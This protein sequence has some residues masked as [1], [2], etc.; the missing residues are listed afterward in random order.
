MSDSKIDLSNWVPKLLDIVSEFRPGSIPTAEQLNDYLNLL[1]EQGDYNSETIEA[2]LS[3][4]GI[5][6]LANSA[7]AD[8][9]K[10]LQAKVDAG[11]FNGPQGPVGEKGEAGPQGPVGPQGPKGEQG[12][13]GVQGTAGVNGTDGK[14]GKDGNNGVI[15][16]IT[17]NEYGFEI[18]DGHLYIVYTDGTDVPTFEL[19]SDY[20]LIQKYTDDNGEILSI[21]LGNVRGPVGSIGDTDEFLKA[22]WNLVKDN[23]NI[24]LDETEYKRA[25]SDVLADISSDT[26]TYSYLKSALNADTLSKVMEFAYDFNVGNGADGNPIWINQLSHKVKDTVDTNQFV[27]FSGNDFLFGTSEDVCAT[28]YMTYAYGD[29]NYVTQITKSDDATQ[30]NTLSN[31]A[32][33]YSLTVADD[34][35]FTVKLCMKLSDILLLIAGTSNIHT[36]TYSQCGA[37]LDGIH[38]D[39]PFI[40]VAHRIANKYNL[41]VEQHTGTIMIACSGLISVSTD[42]DWSGSTFISYDYNRY[43]VFSL[44]AIEYA[45]N[46]ADVLKNINTEIATAKDHITAC[47]GLFRNYTL[48]AASTP[49]HT[50]K[51]SDNATEEKEAN[52]DLVLQV[53]NGDIAYPVLFN[54]DY[55]VKAY[56]VPRETIT[57]KGCNIKVNK[58]FASVQLLFMSITRSNVLVKDFTIIPTTATLSST[59]YNGCVFKVDRAYNVTFSNI[60]AVNINNDFAGY[61]IHVKS[62]LKI[63]IQNSTM[64]GGWGAIGTTN[65]KE[66]TIRDC[67]LN[68]VDNHNYC[69][70]V[71]VDNCTITNKG[72]VLGFGTGLVNINKCTFYPSSDWIVALRGEYLNP[73]KENNATV[74]RLLYQGVINIKD[75]YI[76]NTSDTLTFAS[77]NVNPVSSIYALATQPIMQPRIS[78]DNIRL[79]AAVTDFVK[80][81]QYNSDTITYTDTNVLYK[82]VSKSDLVQISN[83]SAIT[84]LGKY[85]LDAIENNADI[86][87]T[88]ANRIVKTN[89]NIETSLETKA[90]N[91]YYDEDNSELQLKVG[92]KILSTTTIKSSSGGSS[93]IALAQPTTVTITSKNQ[94]VDIKW[95]DPEDLTY[96]GATLAAWQKTVVVRKEGSAPSSVN[97]G[98]I[99]VTTTERNQYAE[100]AYTDSGLTNDVTYYYGIFPCS[101]DGVYTT[102]YTIS[103]VPTALKIVTFVD[104]TDEEIAAMLDAHYAGTINIA[105]YWSVG[106][107]RTIHLNAM[108][109]TGVN[110]SHVAQDQQFVII[111]IEHDDLKTPIKGHTKA[112]ITIQ[113]LRV[114][115]NGTRGEEGYMNKTATTTGG[116]ENCARRAWCNNVFVKALPSSVQNLIKTVSKLNYKVHNSTNLT[117]TSDEAFLLSKTE[118]FGTQNNSVGNTEGVQY[119]YYKTSSNRIKYIGNATLQSLNTFWSERS[120]ASSNSFWLVNKDGLVT[121]NFADNTYGLCPA[122]CL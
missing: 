109:A 15:L 97:D 32:F 113:P 75:C 2:I 10:D 91:I 73:V 108:S 52:V 53:H 78:V 102:T 118:I 82:D 56:E 45:I 66:L 27:T 122:F 76:H 8:I 69:G 33:T 103:A 46:D 65:V 55:D 114:L 70:N 40:E 58:K 18:K 120:L 22:F 86:D 62:G 121:Y 85:A 101:A 92:N 17:G 26:F 43:G 105:D 12:I 119:E 83:S 96:A 1:I 115:S 23:E 112:A 39:R 68:R 25:L 35:D 63:T 37:N 111:G 88:L 117:T 48:L 4:N 89:K 47:E 44:N 93:G 11:Y 41:K 28:D 90:D 71:T 16:N 104:G 67:L 110:E 29:F 107:M 61:I 60:L 6:D 59:A 7:I 77:M 100:T 57:I 64:T 50:R 31:T 81:A 94:A 38:D 74:N 24:S 87:G 20:H 106:D 72:I 3:E 95:T 54:N 84:E 51:E 30:H 79:N 5:V 21:D 34:T 99:V 13:Q 19:N 9:V 42:V 80:L 36:I 98:T 116:W 14:D 49:E